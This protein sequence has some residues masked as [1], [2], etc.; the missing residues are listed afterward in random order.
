MVG[1]SEIL[2]RPNGAL[3][4][5]FYKF[6]KKAVLLFISVVF[7]DDQGVPVDLP[8]DLAFRFY[9]NFFQRIDRPEKVF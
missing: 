5:G 1:A 3:I 2:V 9:D 6:S 4:D 8:V 7:Q